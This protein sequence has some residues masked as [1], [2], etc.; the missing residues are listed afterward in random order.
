MK[1]FGVGQSRFEYEKPKNTKKHSTIDFNQM[2]S[3]K[4]KEV[5]SK[6]LAFLQTIKLHKK[7][8]NTH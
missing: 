6:R 1:P 8:A 2:V 4:D 7:M 3:V 5:Y